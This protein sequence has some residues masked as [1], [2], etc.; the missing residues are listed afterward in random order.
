MLEKIK[1]YAPKTHDLVSKIVTIKQ[2]AEKKFTDY[3]QRIEQMD[4]EI[5]ELEIKSIK[6]PSNTSLNDKLED[7]SAKRYGLKSRY[8]SIKNNELNLFSKAEID[9]LFEV[10]AKEYKDKVCVRHN[11][12]VHQYQILT[13][14]NNK[15]Q[16]ELQDEYIAKR[17]LIQS[18]E[19]AL[20]DVTEVLGHTMTKYLL[21]QKMSI[22]EIEKLMAENNL[23]F[24]AK[25]ERS[26]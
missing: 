7:L 11:E 1:K 19:Y 6:D 20:R 12:V 3:E 26:L 5:A 2:N 8:E 17:S 16:K 22:K 9:K 10:Y 21:L 13:E 25:T 24:D 4:K 18:E 14:D 15:K 23:P